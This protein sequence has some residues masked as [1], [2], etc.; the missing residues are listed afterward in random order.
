MHKIDLGTIPLEVVKENISSSSAVMEFHKQVE[1]TIKKLKLINSDSS[2]A[3][4]IT[5]IYIL[6]GIENNEG[7]TLNA[8]DY[9]STLAFVLNDYQDTNPNSSNSDS[10]TKFLSLGDGTNESPHS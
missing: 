3:E 4:H 1:D 10:F 2:I 6:N 9:L 7:L 5:E 8:F